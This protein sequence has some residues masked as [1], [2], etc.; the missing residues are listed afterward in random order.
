MNRLRDP[1]APTRT[2]GHPLHAAAAE[3]GDARVGELPELD[4]DRIN[5][6]KQQRYSSESGSS[7]ASARSNVLAFVLEALVPARG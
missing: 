3:D 2:S 4:C 6:A 7:K 5:V 1:C